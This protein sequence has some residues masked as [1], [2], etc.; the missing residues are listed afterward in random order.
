MV[1]G[2]CAFYA[3]DNLTTVYY[4]GTAADWAEIVIVNVNN[5]NGKVINATRYYYSETQPMG[6]GYYWHYDENGEI[7]VW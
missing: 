5:Y 7:V 1:L 2:D 6:Q 4:K 3:C